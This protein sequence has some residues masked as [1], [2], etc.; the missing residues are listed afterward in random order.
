MKIMK[1]GT[2]LLFSVMLWGCGKGNPAAPVTVENTK[3]QHPADWANPLNHGANTGLGAK[4]SA[5]SGGGM[6]NCRSCHGSD[7][8]GGISKVSCFN[9]AAC[10]GAT[11]AA[12]HAK[13]PWSGPRGTVVG[14]HKSADPGNATACFI[15]HAAGNNSTLK[16]T[17]VPAPG[18]KPS[19]FNNTLCHA[20][21][22]HA[23]PF[24]GAAHAPGGSFLAGA[25]PYNNCSGCHDTTV[26]GAAYG[27]R[28]D[29][30]ACHKDVAH[31][32]S[33]PGCGDC[34]GVKV[35]TQDGRPVGAVFP[36]RQFS[37]G[38]HA[39]TGVVCSA[40]HNGFGSGAQTH[41]QS[42]FNVNPTAANVAIA[43]AYQA[44]T[45]GVAGYNPATGQCANITCHG[46]T[47]P[48]AINTTPD[49]KA[50]AANLL[51]DC[52]NC[53]GPANNA[54]PS[55]PAVYAPSPVTPQYNSFW[56][57][58]GRARGHVF[59][60]SYHTLHLGLGNGLE[61][62]FTAFGGIVCTDCH[63]ATLLA[64][65]HFS[66]LNTPAITGAESSIIGSFGYTAGNNW[67]CAAGTC[68]GRTDGAGNRSW[69]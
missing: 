44:E 47:N 10:H 27:F 19:C 1:Y 12:A 13:K 30:S 25:P 69:K 55:L 26:A 34:H 64:A 49:W 8:K 45:G 57:G 18:A 36:D 43:S 40:C 58:D 67:T 48:N 4:A 28:P 6:D 51:A 23:F 50:G 33:N 59:G 54:I 32:N 7:F 61:L 53:H 2:I 37:H 63:D 21:G 9:N 14:T 56:S 20:E 3:K 41:G 68:H 66:G 35:G 29:C 62:N 38:V 42:G 11:V 52:Y 46:G 5:A 17:A 31:L 15:C 65:T 24:P 39:F 16:P 60:N 22:A